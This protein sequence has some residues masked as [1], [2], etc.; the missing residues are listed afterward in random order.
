[1]NHNYRVVCIIGK[2]GAGKDTVIDYLK[3]KYPW[4]FNK[5]INS[6]TRPIREKE[7]HGINY[8]YLSNSEFV[9]KINNN[10]MIEYTNFNN[11]YYGTSIENFDNTKINIG[12]FNPEGYQALKEK[13]FTVLSIYIDVND[14]ERLLRQLNREE[15]PNVKEII[16]RFSAD[17]QDFNN[18]LTDITINGEMPIEEAGEEILF[19]IVSWA[20][21]LPL[22]KN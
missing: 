17:E 3:N 4:V 20:M 1:M 6:T 21:S 15:N 22:D 7:V 12:A 16:R 11:W 13:R 18:V 19:H 14:K 9:D 10:K 5:I 2:A 8:Y